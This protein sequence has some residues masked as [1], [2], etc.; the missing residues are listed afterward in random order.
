MSDISDFSEE[1]ISEFESE[2]S[3]EEESDTESV[4]SLVEDDSKTIKTT[5]SRKRNKKIKYIF[6]PKNGEKDQRISPKYINKFEYT[7]LIGERAEM[8]GNGSPVH[9]KYQNHPNKDPL[10]VAKLELDDLD[11]PFPLNIYRKV[12]NPSCGNIV[13]VF[14]PHEPGIKLFHQMY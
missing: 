10:E 3:E 4:N 1:S 13:E 14:N 5:G 8:I 9:P 6:A 12:D 7:R 2:K 11:I